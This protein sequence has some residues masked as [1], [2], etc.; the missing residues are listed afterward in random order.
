MRLL[1]SRRACACVLFAFAAAS[2]PSGT[3]AQTSNTFS[4]LRLDASPRAAA[5]AGALDAVP[6]G[7]PAALFYNPALIAETPSG[8]LSLAYT[9]HLADLNAGALAYGREVK[10]VRA[11]VGVRFLSWGEFDE[12]DETGAK[13]GTFGASSL[14]LTLGAAR[15]QTDRLNVG[16]SIHVITTGV[17]SYRA[18]AAAADIGVTYALP[19]ALTVSAAVRNAGFALQSLGASTDELPLDVRVGVSKRLRYLPLLVTATGYD[20]QDPGAGPADRSGFEQA[21]GHVGVGAELQFSPA[22]NLRAGYSPRRNQELRTE[23]RLDTAGLGLGFGLGV[24]G[25]VLDYAFSSWSGNGA[26]H[27][28]AVRTRL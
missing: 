4:F 12:A 19:G 20:L 8:T 1:P 17:S 6:T 2:A 10:G 25:F 9:N 13:T 14:A 24:R 18:T 26:L 21:L 11:A 23:K 16:A 27:Q 5:L 3:R 7:D 15:Q 22:F 28:F